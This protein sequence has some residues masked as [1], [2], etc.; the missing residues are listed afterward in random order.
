MKWLDRTLMTSPYYYGLCLCEKA[1][2]KEMKRLAIP[3]D[4]RPAFILNKQS[5]ATT[6]FFERDDGRRM[7]IVTI[8]KRKGLAAAQINALLV[9]EAVH[10]WQ[11]IREDIGERNPSSEFEAYSV[12]TISQSLMQAYQDAKK[13]KK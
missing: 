7:A 4:E 3:N 9:H 13:A 2:Q 10:I 1:F 5:D 6:H 11:A 8:R 12:Q